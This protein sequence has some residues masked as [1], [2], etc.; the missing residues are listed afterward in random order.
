MITHKFREV[1][2]HADDVSVL[3][4]GKLVASHAVAEVSRDQNW[5][6]DGRRGKKRAARPVR[7]TR[8][9][10]ATA[11]LVVQGLAVMGDRGETGGAGPVAGRARRRDRR[12]GRR[13]GQRPARADG[14]A[15]RPARDRRRQVSVAGEPSTPRV[16]RTAA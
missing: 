6:G 11:R 9:T 10:P 15:G 5:P 4:R 13:L 12:R 2:E 8:A 7:D 14:S 16:P 3:R 1:A